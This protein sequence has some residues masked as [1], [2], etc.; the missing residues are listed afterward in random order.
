MDH[1]ILS[2]FYHGNV[3]SVCTNRL[4]CILSMAQTF[5]NQSGCRILILDDCFCIDYTTGIEQLG[6]PFR[7]VFKLLIHVSKGFSVRP[8]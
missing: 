4:G 5:V 3:K 8:T 1:N 2:L 6:G 7:L